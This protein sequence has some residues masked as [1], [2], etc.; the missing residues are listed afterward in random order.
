VL[1][2]IKSGPDTAEGA[3]GLALA[4]E[5]K[6]DLVLL[7][8]GVYFARSGALGELAGTVYVLEE[9]QRL[10]GLKAAELDARARPIGYDALTDLITRGDRVVGM[11]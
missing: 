11:F 4:R 10:R 9:D 6:A 5:N 2:M 7:Q 3:I 8:D 1:A